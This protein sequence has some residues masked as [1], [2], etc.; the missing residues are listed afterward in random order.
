MAIPVASLVPGRIRGRIE[1]DP[2]G[3][4]ADRILLV[5]QSRLAQVRQRPAGL[6]IVEPAPF[7]HPVI[8]WCSQEIPV[9]MLRAGQAQRLRQG[10]PV[11]LDT[12]CG[13]LERAV[14]DETVAPWSA[15]PAPVAGRPVTMRDG[16]RVE[17]RASIGDVR[18]ATRA[19]RAGAT[20]IGLVR[21][22]YLQP[23]DATR[24]SAGF[25]AGEFARLL[26]AA[27]SLP[28]HF[29]LLDLAPDKWPA[30][31]QQGNG[32]AERGSRFG[33]RWYDLGPVREVVQAQL[34]ALAGLPSRRG[35]GVL[36]PAGD[37]LSGYRAGGAQQLA[38]LPD[39]FVRGVMIETVMEALAIDRWLQAAD[40]V[41]LGGND[42]LQGLCG[43]DREDPRFRH[44]LDPYRPA[45]FRFYREVA[46]Q[47]GTDL[48]RVQ[49]CGLLPQVEG[50][51]PVLVGL[52]YRNFSVEPAMIPLLAQQLQSLEWTASQQ[53]ADEVC[54][55]PD[56]GVV[57]RLLGLPPNTLWG[58][59]RDPAGSCE[60]RAGPGRQAAAASAPPHRGP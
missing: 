34:Q 59:L 23:P 28:V 17:L 6:L 39:R 3:R 16:A 56:R 26:A 42:L 22:E 4:V 45:L 44:M 13:R 58:L 2:A 52:G 54:G 55:A 25:Y 48:E 31:L 38:D 27:D 47:A 30:W 29:R 19:C 8:R 43:A 40:F 24:P 35:L 50:L 1:T 15:P 14:P 32:A 60:V 53:L 20:A 51:L 12:A 46:R 10:E 37:T 21:T 36:W 5:S 57:R 41:A 18:G 11:L 9:G 7:S 49:L 33:S